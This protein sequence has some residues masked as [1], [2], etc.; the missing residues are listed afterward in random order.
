MQRG[1]TMSLGTNLQYLRR[2]R[3][4]MTQEALAEKLKVSRQTVSKWESDEAFP[5]IEKIFELCDFFSCTMDQL[6]RSDMAHR[7]AAYSEVRLDSLDRFRMA[8]HA[9]I[10]ATPEDDAMLVLKHWAEKSG[11]SDLPGQK[12]EIIGW[13]FP[14]LSPE[15]TNVFNMR[16]YVA[17]CAVPADFKPLCDGAEL[18]WQEAGR[19]AALTITEPFQA[20]FERIPT[21]YKILL[22]YLKEHKL[23]VK[24]EN[25]QE[26][27]CFEKIYVKN[28][29]EYMEIFIA[30]A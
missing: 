20:A 27:A 19:Y 5:A 25:Q 2:L 10:S 24:P 1:T 6:L 22:D 13:D 30:L 16:G 29:V 26:T 18:V 21:G 28:G 17:A 11:L 4:A 14:F 15:Q 12:F 9:V 8:R 23:A 7:G 3:D